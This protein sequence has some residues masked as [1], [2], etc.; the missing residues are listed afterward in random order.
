MD[1]MPMGLFQCTVTDLA[2]KTD[3]QTDRR[4]D[5]QT[6]M[7]T[8]LQASQTP[9]VFSVKSHTSLQSYNTQQ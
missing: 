6:D 8:P 1:G 2:E 3:R 4:T 5:R 7:E 9:A